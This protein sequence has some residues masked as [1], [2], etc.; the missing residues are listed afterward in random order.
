MAEPQRESERKAVTS[1]KSGTETIGVVEEE[2]VMVTIQAP[3]GAVVR[4]EKVDKTGKRQEVTE[5]DWAKLIGKEE[6]D[7]IETA[8][9]EAFEAGI[10]AVLGEEYEDGDRYEDE[11]ER[12]LRRLLIGGLLRKTVRRRILQRMMATRL[13]RSRMKNTPQKGT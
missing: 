2:Q 10:A 6:V 1:F 9:E 5:E 11:E 8:I 4:V 12:A 3:M 13:L 7:E